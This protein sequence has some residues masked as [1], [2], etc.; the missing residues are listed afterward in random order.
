MQVKDRL[1]LRPRLFYC[2][3]NITAITRG[4][5]VVN[6]LD[7]IVIDASSSAKSAFLSRDLSSTRLKEYTLKPSFRKA[8]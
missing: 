4:E 1:L 8:D 2:L 5:Q 3:V 6:D 7:D